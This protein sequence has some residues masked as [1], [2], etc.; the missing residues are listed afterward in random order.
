MSMFH[1]IPSDAVALTV[2]VENDGPYYGRYEL[3]YADTQRM[4]GFE[5]QEKFDGAICW[6]VFATGIVLAICFSL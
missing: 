1:G 5:N 2:E 4:I 3:F 6:S